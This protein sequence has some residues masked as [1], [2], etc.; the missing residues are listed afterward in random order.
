MQKIKTILKQ[1]LEVI[2]L[3]FV[4]FSFGWQCFEEHCN[5]VINEYHILTINN[6]LDAIW[7]AEYDE[8]LHSERY[9][10][11]RLNW[12][13]YE[14][15]NDHTIKDWATIKKELSFIEK[16]SNL[17][18]ICRIFL[19]IIGSCFIICPKLNFT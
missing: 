9:K 11:N 8:A 1:N 19:Y 18:W 4:L 17:G 6:K 15:T 3:T 12:F 10:G 16:E 5:Q 2:G 7:N 14:I 13:G